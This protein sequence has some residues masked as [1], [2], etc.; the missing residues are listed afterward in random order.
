MLA[1]VDASGCGL[2][3]TSVEFF[4]EKGFGSLPQVTVNGAQ[5]SMDVVRH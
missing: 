5:I 4:E 1:G 2:L 3:Q